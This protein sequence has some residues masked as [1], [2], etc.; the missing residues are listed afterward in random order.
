M[1]VGSRSSIG[2]LHHRIDWDLKF[3]IPEAP[4]VPAH[5]HS[6]TASPR[7]PPHHHPRAELYQ[8]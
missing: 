8:R 7:T 3:E 6:S 2:G 1:E 4:P 5:S